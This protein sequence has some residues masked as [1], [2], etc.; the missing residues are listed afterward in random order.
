M[1][2]SIYFCLESIVI[3]WR[4]NETKAFVIQRNDERKKDKQ[5]GHRTE[6]KER[7][8]EK[9]DEKKRKSLVGR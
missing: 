6:K 8:K 7:G 4:E 2:V 5:R 9:K 3:P 1:S